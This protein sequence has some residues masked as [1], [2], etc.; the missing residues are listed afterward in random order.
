LC[1]YDYF[2]K[3]QDGHGA[4]SGDCVSVKVESGVVQEKDRMIL[5]PVNEKV[6]IKRIQHAKTLVSDAHAG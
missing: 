1:I 2:N 6:E 4:L 3:V 5:M